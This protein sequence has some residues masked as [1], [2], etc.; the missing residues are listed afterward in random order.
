MKKLT[1]LLSAVTALA[2]VSAAGVTGLANASADVTSNAAAYSVK[3]YTPDQYDTI[4][5]YG[6][7]GD[8]N[9]SDGDGIVTFAHAGL[10][11]PLEGANIEFNT[12]FKTLSAKSVD[13]GGDG[14]DC[15]L[16]YS[17]SK[18]VVDITSDGT[19][20]SPASGADGVF[21]HITNYSGNTAPNCVEMQIVQ[22]LNGNTQTVSTSFVDNIVDVRMTFS[23]AQVEDTYTLTLYKMDTTEAIK[24]ISGLALNSEAFVNDKGQTFVSTAIYEGAGCDGNHWEHRGLSIYSVQAYNEDIGASDV[25]LSQ[26]EYTYE[27]VACTP[28][29]TV[30]VG[31]VELVNGVDYAVEYLNNNA[32]GIATAKVVFYGTLG[33]NV[34]EKEFVINAAPAVEPPSSEDQTST[35]DASVD[36]GNSSVEAPATSDENADKGNGCGSAIT[37]GSVATLLALG[38]VVLFVKKRS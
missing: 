28:D 5:Y 6:G 32:V 11:T 18:N 3:E 23:L 19:I 13:N 35:P 21:L 17:F 1:K 24:T 25:V 8:I 38:G 37:L 7:V 31:G 10:V 12:S 29:V 20:P 36:E 2:V 33:G 26:T 27:D 30:T 4:N 16:T 15:W 14:V 22:R 9:P 34:V